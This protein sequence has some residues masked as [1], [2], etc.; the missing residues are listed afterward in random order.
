MILRLKYSLSVII[1]PEPVSTEDCFTHHYGPF[2]IRCLGLT[3]KRKEKEETMSLEAR[4]SL[5]QRDIAN[6]SHACA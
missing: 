3:P 5:S 6:R 4:K 2:K 1:T